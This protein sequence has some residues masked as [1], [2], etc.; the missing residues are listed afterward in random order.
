MVGAP[1][2][3]DGFTVAVGAVVL[4]PAHRVLLV[5][6]GRPPALGSWTLPGGRVEAGESLEAAIV[7]EVMEETALEVRVVCGLG[8]VRV[9]REGFAYA[10]HEYLVAPMGDAVPVAGDDAAEV[11]WAARSELDGL[12][13][14]TEVGDVVDQAL[15][16]A[17]AALQRAE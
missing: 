12:G 16:Q 6:R 10:I 4:D 13:V 7:R 9:A 1:Q 2:G 5:R 3:D 14:R 17:Q 11:R 8:A 15:A